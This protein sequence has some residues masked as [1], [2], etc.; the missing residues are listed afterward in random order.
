MADE[1]PVMT[2]W[3]PWTRDMMNRLK[4]ALAQESD[5]D[6]SINF[7]GQEVLV[8]F[9]NYLVEFLEIEFG[10]RNTHGL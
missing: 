10:K 6:A 5:K 9:G 3:G 2:K 4:T 1:K 8:S 7:D